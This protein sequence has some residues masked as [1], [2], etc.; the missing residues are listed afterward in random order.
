MSEPITAIKS[1]FD[2]KFIVKF[3]V[4]LFIANIVMDGISKLTGGKLNLS[5]WFYYP[6]DN[7]SSATDKIGK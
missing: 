3:L 2:W 4:A 1:A 7:I 6:L 5:G